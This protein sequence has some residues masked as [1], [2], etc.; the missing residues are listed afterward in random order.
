MRAIHLSRDAR[1]RHDL[2]DAADERGGLRVGDVGA[3]RRAAQRINA[4]RAAGRA[5]GSPT[6]TA[7][8]LIAVGVLHEVFHRLVDRYDT[9]IAPGVVAGAVAATPR[10]AGRVPVERTIRGLARDF[11]RP[12]GG[13]GGAGEPGKPGSGPAAPGHAAEPPEDP[14][15]ARSEALIEALLLAVINEDPAAAALRD[16][17]DDGALRREG[18]YPRVLATLESELEMAGEAAGTKRVRDRGRLA[19]GRSSLAGRSL[20]QLLR[21]PSAASPTSLAGQLRWIREHWGELITG[22]EGL[23]DRLLLASDLVAE[24]ERALHQRFGGGGAGAAETPDFVGLDAEPEGFSDD[25][26]WM[27]RVVLQAKSTHVWLDQLSRRHGREIRTLDAV[28]DEELDRLAAWGV[29]GL[30]LIGLW[31]RSRASER[32]KHLRGNPDAVASAYSLDAYRIADDLGGEAA[33]ASLRD[34]AAARGI[35]LAS[36]MVPNHM[37]IDSGWVVEHPDRFLAVPEAPYPAYAFSGPDLSSDPAVEI[38]LEDHYWSSSD[39]AVV[40]RRRDTRSGETR[41]IYHGNDGTSF[42]WNDTAQL[43]YLRTEVREAVLATIVEV[44]RRFPIIRFDAAMVL[45]RRHVRRLWW[46][47]PGTGGGIPSRAEHALSDAAFEAAMP[48]EFWRDVVDRVASE[49]PGTLL[50][51]EAFWLMEG[52]FVRTLGMHRVYNSAFMHMLRDEDGAGYRK[53]IRETIEFDRAILGRYVNFMSNPDEKSAIEQFGAGD[54]YFGVATVLATLPG[55]PMLAHGQV[56]GLGER[57]GMEYRQAALDEQ[58]DAAL[59]ERHERELF[60][61]LRQRRRFAGSEDFRLYDLVTAGGGVDEH[62]F[63]YSNGTGVERSLVVYHDRFGSAAG[64]IRASVAFAVKGE[65]GQ[66]QLERTALADALGLSNEPDA[67]VSFR[68]PRT[69]HGLVATVGEVRERGLE[70]QLGA[71]ESRAWTEIEEHPPTDAL[72]RRLAERLDGAGAASLDDALAA[73]RLLPIHEPLLA[74]VLAVPDLGAARALVEAAARAAGADTAGVP[75]A[76]ERIA[77]AA[78]AVRPRGAGP[79]AR[80]TQ[81]AGDPVEAAARLGWAALGWLPGGPAARRQAVDEHALGWPLASAFARRGL[82]DDAADAAAARA[83]FLIGIP[84]PA[85]AGG[86]GAP[87]AAIAA[88]LAE[89]WLTDHEIG[90]AIG[91]QVSDGIEYVSAEGWTALVSATSG[92]AGLAS[93]A[94]GSRRREAA[95][96]RRLRAAGRESGYRVEAIRAA[97]AERVRHRPAPAAGRE[98]PVSR[99]ATIPPRA[100]RPGAQEDEHSS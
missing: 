70:L 19:V 46:P 84:L 34:R 61:L 45:A 69:G 1:H 81:P 68:D 79:R 20:P 66:R 30:W 80:E 5:P 89:A 27:P 98:P 51:A 56:E 6:V 32:I 21:A 99:R 86:P 55:L 14:E 8:E 50:L 96:L 65:G 12:P 95:A 4:D 29:T 17:F 78:R 58:P 49:V 28:P 53:V 63:A 26:D 91:Q 44:A 42:P 52:Y 94:G 11:G 43:D 90:A 38:L 15:A 48:T 23:E 93:T 22:V 57:Y 10:I 100:R 64:R 87:P 74:A 35:R 62:V 9:A 75:V 76:L 31:Q 83:R 54:K 85:E 16:L 71:Y 92:L 88:A 24:E 25:T 67:V 82:D 97:L 41:F 40:F 2:A 73:I 47:R 33:H 59:V 3:A 13:P 36:D 7:G 72:W 77:R 37:G 39:A 60:P 18:A